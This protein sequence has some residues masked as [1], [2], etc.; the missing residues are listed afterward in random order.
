MA[1]FP[2]IT[3]PVP[4]TEIEVETLPLPKEVRSE[5]YLPITETENVER[6]VKNYFADIPLMA[7]IAR[8]ESRY[9]HYSKGD[10][11][12]GEKNSYD[13]GVM[14]I[15]ILYHQEDAQEMGLDLHDLDD[16]VA[17]ARYLYEKYGA[18]PWMSSSACW[19]KF[20]NFEIA[21]R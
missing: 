17:Y 1:V 2:A 11:L 5:D 21:K 10:V 3:S 9:R 18:K 14:Q 7:K 19:S 15:N 8:C 13:R 6:F 4:A 16:N 20:S 12:H